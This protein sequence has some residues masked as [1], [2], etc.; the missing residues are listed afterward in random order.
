[1][2]SGREGCSIYGLE[3]VQRVGVR[4]GHGE[5]EVQ[6]VNSLYNEQRISKGYGTQYCAWA[7]AR[8]QLQVERAGF[9]RT[10]GRRCVE[11]RARVDL[12]EDGLVAMLGPVNEARNGDLEETLRTGEPQ[13]IKGLEC[14]IKV[15]KCMNIWDYLREQSLKQEYL[16]KTFHKFFRCGD[17][18]ALYCGMV[19]EI[20]FLEHVG[21]H[22]SVIYEDGDAE[23]IPI[24]ELSTLLYVGMPTK[25]HLEVPIMQE[26]VQ[27][28]GTKH[29][30][31]DLENCAYIGPQDIEQ[32]RIGLANDGDPLVFEIMNEYE[33]SE[34][35]SFVESPHQL[36]SVLCNKALTG[37]S[38]LLKPEKIIAPFGVTLSELCHMANGGVTR[39]DDHSH[40]F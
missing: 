18:G 12:D 36:T 35:N 26:E 7:S 11:D 6:N 14:S 9:V 24:S 38:G 20:W 3:P 28:I 17:T 27:V 16:G 4:Y 33:R 2:W 8:K 23:D 29:G 40:N 39:E 31:E 32:I 5:K 15:Q 1:M 22:A 13:R 21:Y 30:F 10:F 19:K 37:P 25:V 34:S